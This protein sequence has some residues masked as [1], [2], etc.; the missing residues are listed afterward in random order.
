MYMLEH[1]PPHTQTCMHMIPAWLYEYVM[2]NP[3][4]VGGGGTESRPCL[5]GLR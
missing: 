4:T 1:M 5:K 3:N 2:Y